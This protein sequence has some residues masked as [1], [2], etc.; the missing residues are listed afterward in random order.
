MDYLHRRFGRVARYAVPVAAA[1]TIAGVG[2]AWASVPDA[3]DV[4][5]ACA[6]ASD[7]SLRVIDTDAG[8][9][10]KDKEQPVSWSAGPGP[11]PLASAHVVRATITVPVGGSKYGEVDCPS[12]EVATGG[13]P[14][15]ITW[16]TDHLDVIES[17]PVVASGATAPSG[18]SVGAT[19]S[20]T[21]PSSL[22]VEA[23]CA[24]A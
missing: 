12:G 15:A 9:T 4:I 17:R 20:G 10:C 7:G 23:V 3:S 2:I 14:S 16:Q 24:P 18:W 22:V 8:A 13:G 1:L 19:N 6:R 21:N 11:N 5:H